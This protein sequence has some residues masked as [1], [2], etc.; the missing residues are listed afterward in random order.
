MLRR[1]DEIP[2]PWT[3]EGSTRIKKLGL[4]MQVMI[5]MFKKYSTGSE[6]ERML[7]KN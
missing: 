2:A 5:Y 4:Q 3:E 6:G 1:D 7:W